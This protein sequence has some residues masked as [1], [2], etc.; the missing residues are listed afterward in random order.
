VLENENTIVNSLVSPLAVPVRVMP[1]C[2]PAHAYVRKCVPA[3]TSTVMNAHDSIIDAGACAALD[4]MGA[5]DYI[6]GAR[7]RVPANV[8]NVHASIVGAH[9]RAPVGN[10]HASIVDARGCAPVRT[11]MVHDR[12][13]N[14]SI[15]RG[16]LPAKHKVLNWAEIVSPRNKREGK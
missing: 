4:D 14:A 10:V 1:A 7:G 8:R 6:V 12:D 3:C 5:Q 13:V 2:V 16:A 9:D 15:G 11:P